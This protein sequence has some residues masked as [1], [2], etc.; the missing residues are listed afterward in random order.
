V[1]FGRLRGAIADQ[2]AV[3]R[4]SIRA[5]SSL[6]DLIPAEDRRERWAALAADSGLPLPFLMAEM[7]VYRRAAQAMG[8]MVAMCACGAAIALSLGHPGWAGVGVGAAIGCALLGLASLAA[9]HKWWPHVE[10]PGKLKT[11]G[12]LAGM[13][14]GLYPERRRPEAA[15]TR[16]TVRD[17]VRAI[18][19]QT[20]NAELDQLD[21]STRFR[22]LLR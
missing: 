21:D 16:E 11:V 22:D 12:E 3:P 5:D 20:L 19:A 8:T 18:A 2:A 4:R 17:T 14:V 15:W 1:A 13:A 9:I 6:E 10:F 7:R